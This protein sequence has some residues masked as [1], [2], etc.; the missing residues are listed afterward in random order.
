MDYGIEV[1]SIISQGGLSMK[2]IICKLFQHCP[3]R[4][5]ITDAYKNL[6]CVTVEWTCL[7]CG[8]KEENLAIVSDKS[9]LRKENK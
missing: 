2:N 6:E 9:G 3:T 4:F 1:L 7:R 8:Y 5:V